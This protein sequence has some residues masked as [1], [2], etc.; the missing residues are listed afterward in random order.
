MIGF[1][2]SDWGYWSTME[3]ACIVVDNAVETVYDLTRIVAG[4]SLYTQGIAS[5]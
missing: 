5:S 2:T 1:E 3:E 4:K